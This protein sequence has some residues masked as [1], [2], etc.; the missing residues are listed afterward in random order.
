[1]FLKY[2]NGKELS[3]PIAQFENV[4]LSVRTLVEKNTLIAEE[5]KGSFLHSIKLSRGT[6]MAWGNINRWN[7]YDVRSQTISGEYSGHQ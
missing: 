6:V 7:K 2:E 1:M 5:V 3:L 4:E